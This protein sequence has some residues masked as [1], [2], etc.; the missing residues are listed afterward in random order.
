MLLCAALLAFTVSAAPTPAKG[1]PSPAPAPSA[2]VQAQ[3]LLS[4]RAI[5]RARLLIELRLLQLRED[6]LD[7]VRR[8]VLLRLPPDLRPT[9][10]L[11]GYVKHFGASRS[12]K[13]SED[14]AWTSIPQ[15]LPAATG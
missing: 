3:R 9:G 4:P 7:C 15:R 6:R 5:R 8:I 11:D 13:G 2:A 1:A 12:I 14:C 10:S